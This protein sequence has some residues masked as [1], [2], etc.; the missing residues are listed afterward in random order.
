MATTLDDGTLELDRLFAQVER[1]KVFENSTRAGGGPAIGASGGVPN[2]MSSVMA[3]QIGYDNLFDQQATPSSGLINGTFVSGPAEDEDAIIDDDENSLLGWDYVEVQG[4][5]QVNWVTDI[6]GP[7]G[8]ALAFSQTSGSVNDQ[9]YLEQIVSIDYYRR[10]V[11]TV[12]SYSDSDD[13]GL[14]IAVTFLDSTDAVIG[15]EMAAGYDE[16]VASVDRFWREPPEL[17]TQARIRFGCVN[18]GVSSATRTVLFISI[19]EPTVY[20]VNIPF[21]YSYLSPAISTQY[22]FSYPSDIIPNGVYI[23]DTQG[24]V[25]GISAKTSDTIS[26]GI[27]TVRAE[28]DTQTT[29]PGPTVALTSAAAKASATASIDG[30]GWYDFEPGDELHMELSTDGD[31]ASTGGADYY[32]SIRLLLVVN[33]EGDW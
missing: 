13:M 29:N 7:D 31:Y 1:R 22:A 23:P 4:T 10:L 33:D 2:Q 32:G 27:G 3:E 12:K 20:S 11:V 30:V 18:Y 6:D 17:A 14:N 28:N 15:T 16:T 25:L 9:V 24:F 5:W 26:A 19:E 21:V 8:Q